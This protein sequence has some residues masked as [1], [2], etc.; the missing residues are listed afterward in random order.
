[1]VF[2]STLPRGSDSTANA[3]KYLW[4]WISIHAPSR[5]R[6]SKKVNYKIKRGI[7]IHAPS[8]ERHDRSHVYKTT[9]NI[10][11]HAPSRERQ[12]LAGVIQMVLVFQSTLPRG[13][14]RTY[15]NLLRLVK[16]FQSTLPRGSDNM[17]V[18]YIS[19]FNRISIHAPS[20][21]R[22]LGQRV[23]RDEI[24]LFQSTLPRGSDI[25]PKMVELW[26]PSFQSTLPRGSDRYHCS[27][28]C[29]CCHFNP[30]SLAGAT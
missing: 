23:P 8:R 17:K 29:P 18:C 21:E 30:R 16:V 28:C 12:L 11:I 15:K 7:S 2:Q 26:P 13:S 1:M 14:D 4:R 22:Q 19:L 6:Q 25:G 10:S 24:K 9:F 27:C 3:I 5:E 20:R